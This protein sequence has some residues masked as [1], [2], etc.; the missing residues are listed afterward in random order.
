M[1]EWQDKRIV[2]TGAGGFIGSHLVERLVKEGASVKAFVH[3]NSRSDW[4]NIEYLDDE[5]LEKVEV[6]AGDLTDPFCVEKTLEG[7]EIVFHLGA[8]IAIPYSYV[9]PWQFA[10]TNVQG[11]VNVLEA[12]RKHRVERIVHTSTSEVY[13]TALYT[14]IDEKH[15]L[16]AQS[17]YSASK[18]GAD[19]IAE[20][21]YRSYDLPI[22]IIRP[23]NTFG[24]RQSARAVIPTII[25][26]GMKSSEIKL[27]ALDPIRDLTYVADTVEGFLAIARARKALG[28]VVNVGS[29]KGIRI[30]DLA[31]LIL[32]RMGKRSVTIVSEKQRQRPERTRSLCNWEPKI[33]LGEG[34]E[35]TIEW[36]GRDE[37]HLK[38]NIYNI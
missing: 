8:L 36:F 18:I 34:L 5:I 4:G 35:K 3:Y 6:T 2:V 9:A 21:Y 11:T 30:K 33:R 12:C 38:S 32:D 17:P 20:S 28:E 19:K 29:G 15:P 24:P 13:G 10:H 14:P 25:S 31:Y 23:F 26:Q 27:G 16:Q 37:A 22:S 1:S 7:S